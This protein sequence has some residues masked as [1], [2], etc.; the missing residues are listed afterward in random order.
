VL[1]VA[2]VFLAAKAWPNLEAPLWAAFLGAIG[3]H[4]YRDQRKPVNYKSI[5]VSGRTI[6]YHAAGR[7]EHIDLSEVMRLS[8]VRE[9]ALFEDLYGPYLETKWLIQM[10]DQHF[11]E[12]MDEWPHRRLLLRTF[13]GHLPGFDAALAR[14]GIRSREK[15]QWVC[16]ER[17]T[18]AV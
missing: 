15:G 7:P 8:F 10:R 17:S 18:S 4:I 14:K 3:Y 11:V 12:V 9:D 13:A 1:A 5:T 2:G 16:F 6:E